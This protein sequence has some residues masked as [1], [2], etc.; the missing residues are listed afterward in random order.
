MGQIETLSL[1]YRPKKLGDVIGQPVV[2]K[3]FTN[4]F[5]SNSLHKAY[6]LAGGMGSGKTSVARIVAAMENCEKGW[7]KDPCG[8]CSNCKEILSG[9]SMEVLERDIASQGGIDDIRSLHK[10]LYQNPVKCRVKY[11]ILD[12]A[13]RL[14]GPAAEA[15]LKMIEEPPPH[16]RFILCTTE[17]HVFKDTIHSRCITWNFHKV[18][19]SEL[20]DHLKNI[21]ALEKIEYEEKALQIASRFAKGSVRNALQNFQTV[22]N[23]AGGNKI[24]EVMARESLGAIDDLLYFELVDAII[25]CSFLSAFKVINKIFGSGKSAKTAVDGMFNHFNILLVARLCPNDMESFSYLSEQERVLYTAQTKLLTGD[26]LLKMMT[27]LHQ[28]SFGI[29]YGMDPD[30]LFNKFAIEAI[31]CQKDAKK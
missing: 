12:E 22:I 14:T 5:K 18:A 20:L 25:H 13:H 26:I 19:W 3:A 29:T 17:P 7:G 1:K 31:M 10:S 28:V 23:Y 16:T 30:K 15:S 27:L 9:N 24:T 2:V 8:E 11:V 21:A 4:A 6:I